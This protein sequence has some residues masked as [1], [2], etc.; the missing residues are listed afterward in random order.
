MILHFEFKLLQKKVF[1]WFVLF[2]MLGF[3][4]GKILLLQI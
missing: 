4:L 3:F 2:C 1:F